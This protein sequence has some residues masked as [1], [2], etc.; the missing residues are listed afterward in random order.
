M[1][2]LHLSLVAELACIDLLEQGQQLGLRVRRPARVA[3]FH[4]DFA[5]GQQEQAFHLARQHPGTGIQ[6]G[7]HHQVGEQLA[8][9]HHHHAQVVGGFHHALDALAHALDAMRRRVQGSEDRALIRARHH[10]A[11]LDPLL[12]HGDALVD[13]S[14][15]KTHQ[16]LER[17]QLGRH[18]VRIRGRESHCG[19][20]LARQGVARG[21]ALERRH[22]QIG[23]RFQLADQTNQNLVGVA[24]TQMNIGAGMTA[25]QAFDHQAGGLIASGHG[26]ARIAAADV[27][28]NA[29]GAAHVELAPLFGI[30]ID[31]VLALQKAG[32]QAQRAAHAGFLIQCQQH[33]DRPVRHVLAI[34][35]RHAQRHADAVVGA[36]RGVFRHQPA[37]LQHRT[38]RILEEVVLGAGVGLAHHVQMALQHHA[39][40]VFVAWGRRFA[41]DQVA[42]LVHHGVQAA[43]FR[44][45]L[46]VIA[47]LLL[48][49]G[50]TRDFTQGLEMLP[51]DFGF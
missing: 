2:H 17:I 16:A 39:D 21:A 36:Q 40:A 34:Q 11:Q 31:Q 30:D 14:Q 5:T 50:R 13:A 25:A 42:D 15:F 33:L 19:E 45:P 48:M 20:S 38:N 24:A 10:L 6:Q 37:V 35:H 46:Q 23:F 47:Q 26:L 41:N 51:D 1:D 8:L 28:I 44:P 4:L 22:A 32:T 3:A 43:Q 7:A 27:D 18:L 49:L 9:F 12:H 29:A